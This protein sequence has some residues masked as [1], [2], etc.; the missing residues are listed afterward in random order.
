MLNNVWNAL[1][2]PA[3][4]EVA[5]WYPQFGN[6]D[7]RYRIRVKNLGEN[8]KDYRVLSSNLDTVATSLALSTRFSYSYEI[9]DY[10]Y[11]R[12]QWYIVTEIRSTNYP[13]GGFGKKEEYILMLT[14]V[15]YGR[16][17]EEDTSGS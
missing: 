3:A 10:I 12:K 6:L 11:Y 13:T 4:K 1:S 14:E 7:K 15:N 16:D 2:D 9:N 5:L 8:R 17:F